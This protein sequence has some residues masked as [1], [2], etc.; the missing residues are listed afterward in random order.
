MRFVRH[1]ED[2]DGN[3]VDVAYY[4]SELCYREDTEFGHIV[5]GWW[6]CLDSELE[7]SEPCR[8][9]SEPIG[10]PRLEGGGGRPGACHR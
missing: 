7:V 2:S 3:L 8:V 10:G 9:C 4:C 1:L 6:P 5:G